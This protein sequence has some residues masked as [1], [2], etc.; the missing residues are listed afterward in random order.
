MHA[1]QG[2]VSIAEQRIRQKESE[3]D[4]QIK[5]YKVAIARTKNSM[6]EHGGSVAYLAEKA[7]QTQIRHAEEIH[8]AK[9]ERS[10]QP[11]IQKLTN[12]IEKLSKWKR[13]AVHQGCRMRPAMRR[14]MLGQEGQ[15]VPRAESGVASAV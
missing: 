13:E 14:S 7:R 15:Q 3:V 6:A 4:D 10:C 12:E 5:Q 11:E 1:L 2:E 9:S 8:H